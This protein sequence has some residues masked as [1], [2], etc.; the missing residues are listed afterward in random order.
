MASH[1]GP[2]R[3][4]ARI[5]PGCRQLTAGAGRCPDCKPAHDRAHRARRQARPIERIYDSPRWRNPTRPA[6]LARDNHTC[7]H[8]GAHATQAAH[9]GQTAQLLNAGVDIYDPDLCDATCASC[10]TRSSSKGGH[11]PRR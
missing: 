1:H 6:V 10:N 8:C 2:P 7:V 3:T 9:R 11:A 5:C 4:V